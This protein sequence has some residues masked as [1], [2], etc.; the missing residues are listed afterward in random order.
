MWFWNNLLFEY[1]WKI[2]FHSKAFF[3]FELTSKLW[4]DWIF[5]IGEEQLLII[6]PDLEA[7]VNHSL[8]NNLMKLIVKTS[9]CYILW[10][11]DLWFL[12][13]NLA[14]LDLIENKIKSQLWMAHLAWLLLFDPLWVVCQVRVVFRLLEHIQI[15][16]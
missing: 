5:M 9:K 1:F 10:K 15:L 14:R 4:K 3:I 7:K 11:N 8:N 13:E 16:V 2:I 6:N 12:C